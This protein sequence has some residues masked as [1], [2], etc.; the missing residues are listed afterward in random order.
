MPNKRLIT[1][2]SEPKGFWIGLPAKITISSIR[3][4]G[5]NFDDILDVNDI[6][7]DGANWGKQI[8]GP[9]VLQGSLMRITYTSGSQ[10]G[11]FVGQAAPPGFPPGVDD[12]PAA[13]APPPPPPLPVPLGLL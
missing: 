1:L 4:S 3:T 6:T 5:T 11:P 7:G 9:G 13:V 12:V 8:L 10:T 2:I